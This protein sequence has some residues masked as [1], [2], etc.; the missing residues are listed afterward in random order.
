MKVEFENNF[1]Y[2]EVRSMDDGPGN[3][4]NIISAARMLVRKGTSCSL[5]TFVSSLS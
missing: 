1:I 4:R 2:E 3:K 5:L